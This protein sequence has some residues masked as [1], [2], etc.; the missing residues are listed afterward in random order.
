MT[1]LTPVLH[2]YAS[3]KLVFITEG[4]DVGEVAKLNEIQVA[5]FA[6]ARIHIVNKGFKKDWS[7]R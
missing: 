7:L 3:S 4:D 1:H 2:T 6:V 5:D